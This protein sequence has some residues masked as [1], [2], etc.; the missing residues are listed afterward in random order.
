MAFTYD[1]TTD[2]GKVRLLVYDTTSG[3]SGTSI[4]SDADIDAFLEQNGNSIWY[5][6]ADAA[7]SR[8]AKIIQSSFDLELTGALR[9][10]RRKQAQYWIDLAMR[11]ETRALNSPD[12]IKEFID[13][14][15]YDIDILGRDTSDYVGDLW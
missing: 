13:S 8:A 2:R 1:P 3:S 4:F 12:G 10:D 14:Y 15:A 5:S 11:Y 7:R 6:A 9:L